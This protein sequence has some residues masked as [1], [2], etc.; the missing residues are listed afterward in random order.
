MAVGIVANGLSR[1][2]FFLTVALGIQMVFIVFALWIG[3]KIVFLFVLLTRSLLNHPKQRLRIQLDF[4]DEK[5]RF[6]LSDLDMIYNSYLTM[7]VLVSAVFLLSRVANVPKGTSF[8]SG[9]SG[10]LLVGQVLLFVFGLLALA[11]LTVG[12][13]AIGAR[14]LETAV[15]RHLK[16]IAQEGDTIKRQIARQQDQHTK[17]EL[18]VLLRSLQERRELVSQQR[19]WPRKNSLYRKKLLASFTLLF[20]LPIWI[21]AL[22]LF[23]KDGL[24]AQLIE[25][26]AT[27]LYDLR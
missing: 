3:A 10:W 12:P 17:L 11:L 24:L 21:E 9:M 23:E 5:C 1:S 26:L 25:G 19:P 22:A 4:E 8:F 6:G 20:I 13:V 14:L 15:S 18:Q 27:F 7:V 16:K 2:Q